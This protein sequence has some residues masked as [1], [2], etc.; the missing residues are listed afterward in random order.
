VGES[1]AVFLITELL[2]LVD[3]FSMS[4]AV[5]LFDFDDDNWR[6]VFSQFRDRLSSCSSFAALSRVLE[7][8]DFE[9]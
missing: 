2:R 3:D 9:L 6:S 1:L 5:R 4:L 7:T 8:S